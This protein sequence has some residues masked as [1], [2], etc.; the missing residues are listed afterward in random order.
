[1]KHSPHLHRDTNNSVQS[2]RNEI[3]A[4]KNGAGG[5]E[6]QKKKKKWEDYIWVRGSTI[7]GRD[8]ERRGRKRDH[9]MFGVSMIKMRAERLWWGRRGRWREC[10]QLVLPLRRSLRTDSE[11]IYSL[12]PFHLITV[13]VTLAILLTFTIPS[14]ES[15]LCVF[16]IMNT[17][18]ASDAFN[19]RT[20]RY[21]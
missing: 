10:W 12:F 1:M 4:C 11:L 13:T 21:R 8:R 5:A 15:F 2:G 19:T 9:G 18:D 16:C 7:R 6:P 17:I 14:S 20:H 3:T